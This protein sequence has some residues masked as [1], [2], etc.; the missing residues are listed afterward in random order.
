[1][2]SRSQAKIFFIVGT[3]ICSVV[4]LG[5]TVDTFRQMPIITNEQNLTPQVIRGKHLWDENN[6][7]GCHTLLGEGGYYA[8]ELT[9]VYERRGPEFIRAMLKD[10][11]AMYPGKRK[12][13]RYN[14]PDEDM[15]ALIAFFKWIGEMDLQGFPPKAQ[16]LPVAVSQ[17][18]H[19]PT[20]DVMT[21]PKIFSQM[22]VACHSIGGQGGVVGPALDGV[23]DRK[24]KEELIAWL[25]DPLKVKPD[26]KMPKLP[27]SEADIIELAAYLTFLKSPSPSGAQ[28]NG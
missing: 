24:T 26:S 10:P 7:M 22:C 19:G 1:M 20:A 5:L 4:F 21:Q 9:K 13:Q 15:D 25:N 6:C 3:T 12:M 27:L 2:F 16:L 23:G 14:L 8:P 28:P 17:G 18:A 11:E